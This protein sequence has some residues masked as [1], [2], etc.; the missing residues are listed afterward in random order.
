M[1]T[2][3]Y[4]L[5]VSEDISLNG[6]LFVSG[7]ASLNG[8]ISL[9][10]NNF[11]GTVS[12]NSSGINGNTWTKDGITW[13]SSAKTEFPGLPSYKAFNNV[14]SSTESWASNNS[15]YNTITGNY[16][17]TETTIVTGADT[18]PITGEWLQIQS[19]VL[20]TMKD[21]RFA[22]GGTANQL[23]REYYILG[24]TNG[25]SWVGIQKVTITSTGYSA[26]ITSLIDTII[27]ID[28]NTDLNYA[29]TTLARV[30][31]SGASSAY[32]Y[33]RIVIKSIFANAN[34]EIGELLINFQPSS[35]LTS[36][37]TLSTSS[38]NINQ[39][40][41]VNQLN[42]TGGVSC[43]GGYSL[44][45]IFP[46]SYA[47]NQIGFTGS[48]VF[49]GT[50][51]FTSVSGTVT[52]TTPGV[53]LFYWSIVGSSSTAA[54]VLETWVTDVSTKGQS[55]ATIDGVKVGSYWIHVPNT[56]NNGQY[57]GGSSNIR[58]LKPATSNKDYYVKSTVGSA[59][60]H[61]ISYYYIRIA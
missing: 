21:Y 5:I 24:S 27:S 28:S 60:F 20:V 54:T 41:N 59:S 34:A 18:S 44:N 13:T 45:Y 37:T 35:A 47:S 2:T 19:S 33:F 17:G 9:V 14:F 56:T 52:I 61:N 23:P 7:D 11:T 10:T 39:S 26:S 15:L 16:Q 42:V 6:R 51:P 48:G 3:N 53:Y 57:F 4:Q 8:N 55:D 31:Y 1:T 22:T 46:P 49:A 40:N 32:T 25:S 58:I 29:S 30:K 43:T 12:P 50:T 36:S 38:N